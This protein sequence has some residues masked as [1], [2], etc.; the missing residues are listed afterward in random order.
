L[1]RPAPGFSSFPTSRQGAAAS[2]Q[3]GFRSVTAVSSGGSDTADLYVLDFLFAEIGP[4]LNHP[5]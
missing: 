5:H 3:T 4:W 2:V 1:Y